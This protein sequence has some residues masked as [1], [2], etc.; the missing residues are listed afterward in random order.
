[1]EVYGRSSGSLDDKSG[2]KW[3]GVDGSEICFRVEWTE[4]AHESDTG[5]R[6]DRNQG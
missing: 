2:R 5:L 1:M 4:S 3:R 6:E